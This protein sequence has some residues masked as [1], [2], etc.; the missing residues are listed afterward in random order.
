VN[1]PSFFTT[2]FWKFILFLPSSELKSCVL[3]AWT[4]PILNSSPELMLHCS[5]V[6]DSSFQGLRGPKWV[7]P[8]PLKMKALCSKH[9][10]MPAQWHSVTSLRTWILQHKTQ[11][12]W[13]LGYAVMSWLRHCTTIQKVAGSI[14]NGFTGIFH[15]HNP[16][17]CTMA[18]GLTRP[19]T[20]MSTRIISWG[21]KVAGAWGW[22]SYHLP[23]PTV[24]K[25]GSLN[26]LEPSGP[27]QTPNGIAVP[28]T[29]NICAALPVVKTWLSFLKTSPQ[30]MTWNFLKSWQMAVCVF[31]CVHVLVI[32][33]VFRMITPWVWCV[34]LCY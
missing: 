30:L 23:V 26:L 8:R 24:L 19:L 1:C 9:K 21:V 17:S 2:T 14:P 27:V 18:L 11:L 31:A 32:W 12:Q 28:C 4:E 34:C 25:S 33:R 15:W 5:A 3:G 20:Q 13:T 29:V 22:Q 10:E 16:S 6:E 7:E